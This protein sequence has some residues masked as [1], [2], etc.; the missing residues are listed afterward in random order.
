MPRTP[1]TVF[2]M[3]HELELPGRPLCQDDPGY[4]RYIISAD[5]FAAQMQQI[6]DLGLRG[7]SVTDALKFAEPAACITFDDGC[8]TD[9][10]RAA[11]ALKELGFGATFYVVSGFI[12]KTGYLSIAQLLQ[13]Q[14]QGFEIACHSMSH[15]YLTDLDQAGLQREIAD[16]KTML[17][18]M[19]GAPVQ[20]FSCPGGRYDERVVQVAKRA[21]YQTVATSIPRANTAATDP[22]ALARVAI[23]RGMKGSEF[24][25]ICRGKS[26][27]Q[28]ALTM[29]ARDRVKKLLGNRLYDRMRGL[30]LKR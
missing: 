11:P 29:G 8:E 21:G 30:L 18:Q 24:Q 6:H 12:G 17:E 15:P 13:L 1:S 10:L 4:V 9:F 23:I 20:H 27:W 28:A 16:A 22:F 7:V 5:E 3:Y 26:L 2:L 19:L 25:R 14:S